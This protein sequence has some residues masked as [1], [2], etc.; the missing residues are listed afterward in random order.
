MN[1]RYRL[2]KMVGHRQK[3]KILSTEKMA[4]SFLKIRDPLYYSLE[5]GGDTRSE[6]LILFIIN[7]LKKIMINH[8]KI[9]TKAKPR[10]KNMLS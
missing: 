4:Q 7:K 2:D 9:L 5:I 1:F 3:K 6:A 8:V 10:H